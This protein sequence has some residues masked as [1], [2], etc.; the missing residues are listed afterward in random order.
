VD[1][2]AGGYE[3]WVRKRYESHKPRTNRKEAAPKPGDGASGAPSASRK[4]TYKDQR[5]YDRLPAE[6]DRMQAEVAQDEVALGDPDLFLRDPDGFAR[7]TDRIAR[8]RAEIEAAEIRWLE[9]A[10]MAEGL[11]RA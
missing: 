10:E 9:V 6:I 8:N 2:V 3:D 4:L 7:I 11:M 5:D 1:V